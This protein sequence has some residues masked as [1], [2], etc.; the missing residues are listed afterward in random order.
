MK[1]LDFSHSLSLVV[2]HS[3]K[4]LLFMAQAFFST[5]K[6]IRIIWIDVW[7]SC[8]IFSASRNCGHVLSSQ[9][10]EHSLI[11]IGSRIIDS[12]NVK[13]KSAC[14]VAKFPRIGRS[15]EPMAWHVFGVSIYN[16]I[17]VHRHLS[18]NVIGVAGSTLP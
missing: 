14:S 16:L 1:V 7:I 17:S 10:L 12:A 18:F 3:A 6:K 13:G 4:V 9:E 11:S 8:D 15:D 5:T 2:V